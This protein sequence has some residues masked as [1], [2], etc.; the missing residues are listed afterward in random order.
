MAERDRQAPHEQ[1]PSAERAERRG[2][3]AAIAL[4]LVFVAGWLVRRVGRR[5]GP[6]LSGVDPEDLAAGHEVSDANTRAIVMVGVGLVIVL[7]VVFVAVTALVAPYAAGPAAL[8]APPGLSPLPTPRL[9][10]EPRLQAEPGQELRQ[11]RSQQEQL[12]HSYGWV[13]RSAGVVRIPVERAIEL[14]AQRGLPARPAAAAQPFRDRADRAPSG[15][16]SGRVEER[17][18]P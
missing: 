1:T 11:Y 4:A 14:L 7:L 5:H 17:I 15:A 9:P 16:S 6:A 10:P 12:L 8:T 13:D 3:L 2:V 18:W